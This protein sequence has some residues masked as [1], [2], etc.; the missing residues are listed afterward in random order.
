L[1]AVVVLFVFLL[2]ISAMVLLNY[3][4]AIRL[5]EGESYPAIRP[6]VSLLVP[7]RNEAENLERL[8]GDLD[9]IE[10]DNLEILILDD[11]SQDD[12]WQILNRRPSAKVS[13]VQGKTLPPAWVGKNWAC[14]QLAELAQGDLFIFC[15][16]DVRVG[17]RSVS[18]TVNQLNRHRAHVLTALMKQV[19][20]SVSERAVIP[21]VMHQ[22]I[23]GLLPLR[24]LVEL[25]SPSA[26]VCS[27]AWLAVYRNAY[28]K[29]GG[30]RTIKNYS[31]EDMQLGRKFKKHGVRVLPVIATEQLSVH[32]YRRWPELRDGFTKNLFFIYGGRWYFVAPTA[33]FFLAINTLPLFYFWG[34][35]LLLCQRLVLARMFRSPFGTVFYHPVGVALVLYLL[36]RSWVATA[37][38][39]LKWKSR[40]LSLP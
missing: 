22:A 34:F 20:T 4:T 25:R 16:A 17:P 1:A 33:V 28:Q 38:G 3:F 30:H 14:H 18:F 10:Y 21:L 15:D 7:I 35:V 40:A 27:G 23:V 6:R 9:K 19:M 2:P 24:W 36:I 26:Q 32:M 39:K 5:E 29:V 31:V 37:R 13:I 11:D 12:S 8:L